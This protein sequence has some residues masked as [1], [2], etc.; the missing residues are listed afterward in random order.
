M[1]VQEVW[2]QGITGKNIVVTILDDGLEYSHPDL[3]QNYVRAMCN[4]HYMCDPLTVHISVLKEPRASYDIN[5][6]DADPSPR[7]DPTN[8]NRLVRISTRV[9]LC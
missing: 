2:R 4:A 5:D 6:D 8:D 1:N 3:R 9:D 7:Y